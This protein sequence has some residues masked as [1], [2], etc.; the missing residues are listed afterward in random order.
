MRIGEVSQRT[1]VS[2]R[3]LRHYE[4]L[5]LLVP[6]GR[7]SAGY[8][9]YGDSDLRRIFHI[10]SLRSLGLGLQEVGQALEDPDFSVAE[11]LEELIADSRSRLKQEKA[12]YD[13]LRAVRGA[14]V[15][16]WD[17]ALAITAMLRDLR[18]ADPARRQLSAL[19]PGVGADPQA[20]ARAALREGNVNVAGALSWA[21][22]S[23]GGAAL[24]EVARGLDSPDIRVRRRAVRILSETPEAADKLLPALADEDA[25]IR[26]LAA[27][28]LGQQG[29]GEARAELLDMVLSGRRD[30]E[31]A[32]TLALSSS[33][34]ADILAEF[35]RHLEVL[36][37][38]DPARARIAQALAE[39]SGSEGLLARLVE[40]DAPQVALTARAILATR[41]STT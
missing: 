25:E 1:G 22:L 26:C 5:G 15:A 38:A 37:M 34:E 6:A 10:E 41:G 13:R 33:G 36:D 21:V 35:A 18:S 7:N 30:V 40:D 3:M 23:A 2:A 14:G 32:E 9:D 4:S 8:R 29:R 19:S 31:A 24:E 16:D 17:E 11:V 20:L 12:L 27:L 28:A 39:F